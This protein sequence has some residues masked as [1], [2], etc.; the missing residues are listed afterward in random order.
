MGYANIK[1]KGRGIHT[2]Q[3]AR[4]FVLEDYLDNRIAFVSMDAGMVGYG[5]KREVREVL[6]E[7]H[8]VA[9]RC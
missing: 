7:Y 3:F 4:A 2:R 8:L 6:I 1:Q 9:N 5:V